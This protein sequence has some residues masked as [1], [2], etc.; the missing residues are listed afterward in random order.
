[1]ATDTTGIK[2]FIAQ[3]EGS[4]A[5]V[6]SMSSKH[7]HENLT[8]ETG[9]VPYENANSTCPV[10]GPGCKSGFT[11][12]GVDL[13]KWYQYQLTGNG[14]PGTIFDST[15]Q[16]FMPQLPKCNTN[17]VCTT[18]PAPPTGSTAVTLINGYTEDGAVSLLTATQAQ[19]LANAALNSTLYTLSKNMGNVLFGQLPSNTQAALADFAWNNDAGNLSSNPTVQFDV[20]HGDWLSLASYLAQN[21]GLRGGLQAGKIIQDITSGKLPEQGM[22]CGA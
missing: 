13:S 21:G 9:Y 6:K 1:M 12:D 2:S 18:P 3:N 15:I 8:N 11:T 19:Q 4:D 7:Y 17:F 5:D 22:P 14:A 20:E 16:A 10:A